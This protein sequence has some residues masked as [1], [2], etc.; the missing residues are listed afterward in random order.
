MAELLLRYHPDCHK[1]RERQGDIS[2]DTSARGAEIL[3]RA[4]LSLSLYKN[5][6]INKSPPQLTE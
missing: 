6:E 5:P 3:K 4:G 2:P 1:D